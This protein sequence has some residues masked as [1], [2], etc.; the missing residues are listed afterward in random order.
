MID[1]LGSRK[2]RKEIAM[3]K[4]VAPTM[5]CTV[6]DRAMQV[7]GGAGVS[8]DTPLALMYA[9]ARSLRIADG[10]DEVHM[11]TVGQLEYLSQGLAPMMSMRGRDQRFAGKDAKM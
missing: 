11:G 7:Y 5:A 6:L 8:A 1:R 3:I 9:T 10:P 4:I 2:A